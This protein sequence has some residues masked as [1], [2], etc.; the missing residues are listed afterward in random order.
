MLPGI[1]DSI[2]L[3]NTKGA[4][5][6]KIL[7]HYSPFYMSIG[8]MSLENFKICQNKNHLDGWIAIDGITRHTMLLIVYLVHIGVVLL[9]FLVKL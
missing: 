5:V 6:V 8:D 7:F 9:L 1:L 4:C 3:Y 2:N